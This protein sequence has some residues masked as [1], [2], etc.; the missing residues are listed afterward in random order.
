MGLSILNYR[1]SPTTSAVEGETVLVG[2]KHDGKGA[3]IPKNGKAYLRV[4]GIERNHDYF[5]NG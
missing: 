2:Y 1:W 4:I 3:L 5:L